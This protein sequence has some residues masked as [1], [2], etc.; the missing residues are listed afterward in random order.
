MFLFK[1]GAFSS[2]PAAIASRRASPSLRK[3]AV[4]HTSW[5]VL[6]LRLAAENWEPQK[7][8]SKI[9]K[10]YTKARTD[11]DFITIP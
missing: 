9:M 11:N 10:L 6:Q 7:A 8:P 1:Q 2:K 4:W 3:Y 5:A